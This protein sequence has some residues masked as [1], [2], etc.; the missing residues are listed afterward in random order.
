MMPSYFEGT[1]EAIAPRPR[2]KRWDEYN[3]VFEARG[4]VI[5]T[6]ERVRGLLRCTSGWGPVHAHVEPPPHAE[7]RTE[8]SHAHGDQRFSEQQK[9]IG[10]W[11]TKP[12]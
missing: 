2:R 3:G 9:D 12:M 10:S 8:A 7:V 6:G 4:C 1:P 5:E 11:T